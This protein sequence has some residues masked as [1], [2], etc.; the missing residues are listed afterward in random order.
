MDNE[1]SERLQAIGSEI[2]HL[3]EKDPGAF[4]MYVSDDGFA[5]LAVLAA[6]GERHAEGQEPLLVAS[7]TVSEIVT[8]EDH[9][10]AVDHMRM[11]VR[12]DSLDEVEVS[13]NCTE[14]TPLAY[15]AQAGI[16]LHKLLD[17]KY[18]LEIY[19][20]HAMSLEDPDRTGMG[21]EAMQICV[22]NIMHRMRKQAMRTLASIAEQI[23][24]EIEKGDDDGDDP[25]DGAEANGKTLN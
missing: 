9:E 14:L 22:G 5:K 11:I 1:M 18:K 2:A 24:S 23:N 16:A 10:H 19:P 4:A 25:D 15:A 3:I 7:V 13:F 20:D 17:G 6:V 12:E 21:K 8:H